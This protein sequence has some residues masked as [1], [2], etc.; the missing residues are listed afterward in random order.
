MLSRQ[1]GINGWFTHAFTGTRSWLVGK[2]K[3]ERLVIRSGR[4]CSKVMLRTVLYVPPTSIDRRFGTGL[5]WSSDPILYRCEHDGRS[6]PSHPRSEGMILH[7]PWRMWATH[8]LLGWRTTHRKIELCSFASYR[9]IMVLYHNLLPEAAR[10]MM[11]SWQGAVINHQ[12]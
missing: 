4:L 11:I 5:G 1:A 7:V 6:T 8:G 2:R 10:Y 3:V 9:S 12:S